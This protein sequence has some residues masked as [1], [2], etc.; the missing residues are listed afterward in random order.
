MAFVRALPAMTQ[1]HDQALA[2]TPVAS[3]SSPVGEAALFARCT[4]CHGTNG[5]GYGQGD[6]L[7]LVGQ[8]VATLLRHLEAMRRLADRPADQAIVSLTQRHAQQIVERDVPQI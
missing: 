3:A 6:I 5:R 8:R 4:E 1:K 7:I 2:A